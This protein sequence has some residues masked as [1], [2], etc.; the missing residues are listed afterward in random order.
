MDQLDDDV[1]KLLDSGLQ[2]HHCEPLL[3][4]QCILFLVY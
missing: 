3:L 4:V 2:A 1:L